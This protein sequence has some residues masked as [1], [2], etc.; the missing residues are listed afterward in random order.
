MRRQNLVEVRISCPKTYVFC[1]PIYCLCQESI[2]LRESTV[3]RGSIE[4]RGI[5][6]TRCPYK[7]DSRFILAREIRNQETNMK[8]G[9]GGFVADDI[10]FQVSQ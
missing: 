4:S 6:C 1:I 9:G 10:Y 3:L 7:E 2:I 8:Y 5:R